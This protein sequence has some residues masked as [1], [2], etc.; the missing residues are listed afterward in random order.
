MALRRLIADKQ[1]EQ[2]GESLGV[3]VSQSS[4]QNFVMNEPGLADFLESVQWSEADYRKYIVTPLLIA[5]DSETVVAKNAEF[6]TE[7]LEKMHKILNDLDSGFNFT[8]LAM[9]RSDDLS[10]PS[11]GDTGY[12]TKD[13]LPAL[14][15][16]MFEAELGTVSPILEAEDFYSIAKVVDISGDPNERARVA[17]QVITVNKTGMLPAFTKFKEQSKIKFFVR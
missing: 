2:F 7:P 6:Q 5:Q 3:H 16:D 8:D 9:T 10:A 15:K 13:E 17:L 14:Y 4:V 12:F 1:L 11:G